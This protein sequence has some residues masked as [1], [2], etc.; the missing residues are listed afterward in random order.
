MQMQ[1]A[2]M[3]PD[4]TG[5]EIMSIRKPEEKR[6]FIFNINDATVLL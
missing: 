2:D 1:A 4:I 5:T 3:K 6:G